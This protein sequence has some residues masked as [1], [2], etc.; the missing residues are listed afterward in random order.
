MRNNLLSIAFLLFFLPVY[1]GYGVEEDDA[2]SPTRTTPPK[3]LNPLYASIMKAI[4]ED[5]P[6]EVHGFIETR[7]GIRLQDDDRISKTATIGETRLQLDLDWDL[8]WGTVKLKSD[9]LYDGVEGDAKPDLREANVL[10]YPLSFLDLKIGRQVL[11]WGTG[12]LIFI[13]DLF[14]KDWQSFF[15]GRDDE[16]LKAPSDAIKASFFHEIANLDVVYTPRFN[17]DRYITGKKI[18]YWSDMLG[19]RAGGDDH[20]DT[21]E[22]NRW[23]ADDEI[24]L[25]LYRN[26]SGYEAA[27][28]YYTGYWKSPGGVDPSSGDAIFPE[29]SV[30]G[31]SIRGN[32]LEGIGN[33]ELGYYDSRD[34]PGGDDPFVRNSEFRFLAGYEQEIAKNLTAAIQYYIEFMMDYDEYRKTLP[35]GVKVKDED[36]HVVTLRL[37]KL[38]MNQNLKLSLFT[39]YCPTDADAYLRPKVHYKFSDHWEGELGGNFFL[40]KDEHTFFGQFEDNTNIYLGFRY[41][42]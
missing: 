28:Y 21:D 2:S 4:R 41:N 13:N 12:D 9:F 36:R 10:V 25:R 27:L 38:L 22:P 23:F 1:R 20:L 11:T 5:L 17:P 14:P 18:S 19:R 40:G 26:I 15:I 30:Y 8:D 35:P 42:F 6:F 16:Y 39:Y 33:L 7:G 3:G 32:A 31:A 37:T 34:D 29:L 24:A